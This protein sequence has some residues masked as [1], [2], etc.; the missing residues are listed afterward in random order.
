MKTFTLDE[1]QAML[2]VVEKLL[3]RALESKQAAESID[4]EL[5][6]LARRIHRTG[7]M[8]INVVAVAQRRSEMQTLVQRARETVQEI[9]EIGVQIKDLDTGLLDFPCRL[10][11]EIV[12]LC[13]KSGETAIEHWHTVE[14]GFNGRQPIDD[15]FRRRSASGG[16]GPNTRPN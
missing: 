16:L 12:L 13:W 2:P 11:E 4:E 3:N 7:G 1:A 15:R 5:T 14:S 10:D 8:S 9:D 6:N